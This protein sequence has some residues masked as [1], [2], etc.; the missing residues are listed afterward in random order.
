MAGLYEDL[1]EEDKKLLS[2]I[3]DCINDIPSVYITEYNR[4]YHIVLSGK[5]EQ[6]EPICDYLNDIGCY[7]KYLGQPIFNKNRLY[8]IIISP[9]YSCRGMGEWFVTRYTGEY[10]KRFTRR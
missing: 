3:F 7:P 10:Y 1:Y 5:G 2:S 9:S 8:N 4:E 6:I